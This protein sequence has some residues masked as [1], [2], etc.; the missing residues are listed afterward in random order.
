MYESD[1]TH[2]PVD[3]SSWHAWRRWPRV[4]PNVWYLG[5]TSLVT[6]VSSEMVTSVLPAYLFM[7]LNLSPLAIGALDGLS[8]GISALMRWISGVLADRWR[9]YKELAALGYA[10]SALCRLGLLWAGRNVPAIASVVAT[11]RIGKAIRTVPRDALIS[12]SVTE[13]QLGQAFGLH[14]TLDAVGAFL[15]PLAAFALLIMLPGAYDVV[16]VT[17]FCIAIV[18]VSVLVLFVQNVAAAPHDSVEDRPSFRTAVGLLRR[19]HFRLVVTAASGLALVTIG[20]AFLYLALRDDVRFAPAVFPLLF[21]GTALFYLML[22]IPA[23]WLSDRI[24]RARM[25]LIGHGLLLACY[26]LVLSSPGHTLGLIVPVALLGAYYAAT[27][28]VV[29]ALASGTLPATHRGSGLAVLMSAIAAARVGA[30]VAF[31]WAWSV[32]GKDTAI[33]FFAV[34]LSAAIAVT[35]A[36]LGRYKWSPDAS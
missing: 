23:G 6:D 2:I 29:V 14:R 9:R 11:D 24:G 17:S 28:G 36:T 27:D 21:V 19:P 10:I 25:F 15:G 5:L 32:F 22:S 31:G 13:R 18:G 4:A 16:F 12:L 3:N 34:A 7:Q 26:A 1:N 35:T 8:N 33:V 20:D 30:S